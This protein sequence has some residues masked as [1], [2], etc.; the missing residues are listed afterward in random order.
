MVLSDGAI[1]A[2]EGETF[3]T[4]QHVLYTDKNEYEFT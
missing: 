3:V 1:S 4:P 2:V